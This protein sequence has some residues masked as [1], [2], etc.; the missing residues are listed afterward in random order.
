[1]TNLIFHS[2]LVLLFFRPLGNV[3]P[4]VLGDVN[5]G[6]MIIGSAGTLALVGILWRG[7]VKTLVKPP[8]SQLLI[9]CVLLVLSL[10]LN[11]PEYIDGVRK[12][13]IVIC[14]YLIISYI[15]ELLPDR[16]KV[17]Q[18]FWMIILSAI[19]PAVFGI[20]EV[21]SGGGEVSS[22]LV[23]LTKAQSVMGDY[24]YAV[25]SFISLVGAGAFL[26][27]DYRFSRLE[28]FTVIV[29]MLLSIISIMIAGYR[30][31][32]VATIVFMGLFFFLLS[33]K[34]M[35]RYLAKKVM[36]GSL[37]TMIVFAFIVLSWQPY[38]E[39]LTQV[40]DPDYYQASPMVSSVAM[41]LLSLYL[42]VDQLPDAP[43]WGN[44]V[45]TFEI[46]A[47][48]GTPDPG[49]MYTSSLYEG[50]IPLFAAII[51]IAFSQL[52]Y[53]FKAFKKIQTADEAIL[54]AFMGALVISGLILSLTENFWLDSIIGLRYWL[55]LAIGYNWQ[56]SDHLTRSNEKLLIIKKET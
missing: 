24:I 23:P 45:G 39:R 30:S 47:I 48:A 34:T 41:R 53:C 42:V 43:F 19:L 5:W 12:L 44:G 10:R 26:L 38:R 17:V 8:A 4:K 29:S 40:F 49:S 55:F 32:L 27:L 14:M 21:L 22:G 18:V 2:I 15:Q 51:L 1:M 13:G 11:S 28:R 16:R 9:L 50:G 3:L 20:I 6:S 52:T 7:Q 31:S 33:R 54:T 25:F 46:D 35:F 37:V 56:F 36:L